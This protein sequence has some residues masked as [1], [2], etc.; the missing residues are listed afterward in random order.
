MQFLRA[1]GK[2]LTR[3][4]FTICKRSEVMQ[5]EL[6]LNKCVGII[7][8]EQEKDFGYTVSSRLPR[9]IN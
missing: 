3:D 9:F 8:K 5:L 4:V 1:L 6:F 7:S 2:C